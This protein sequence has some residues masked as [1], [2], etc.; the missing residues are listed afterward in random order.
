MPDWSDRVDRLLFDGEVVETELHVGTAT[1]V[2][3]SH[4]VLAFT[5]AVDGAD[6]R[7]IDRP[8]VRGVERRS[9]S[10][11]DLRSPA[12]KLGAVGGLIVLVA[13][14]VDPA[15]LL[16]RPEVSDA[17]TAGGLVET[18][19]RAI[20]LF[21]AL[22]AL[23]LGFGAL[24]VAVAVGLQGLEF[25]TR[26]ERVAIE[27]VGEEPSVELPGTIGDEEVSTLADALAPPR[28]PDQ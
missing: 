24:L 13:F 7:A 4:R 21:H 27:V 15:S 11:L 1:V 16:P 25:A 28:P 20:G 22:D 12:A 26:R 9:V 14:V 10:D 17:P 6:Y 5:P 3:T 19:D 23:L 8:N 2:V 18:V